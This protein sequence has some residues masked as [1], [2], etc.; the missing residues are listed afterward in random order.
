[1]RLYHYASKNN[2]ILSDGL[3]SYTT[4]PTDLKRYSSYAKSSKRKDVIDWMEKTFPGRSKS[5]SCLTEP[6]KWRGNDPVL[7]KIVKGSTLF[8]F[9]LDDLIKDGLVQSI[10]C[11]D[12]LAKKGKK[13][14]IHK[15]C[16]QYF[17]QVKPNEIDTSPLTWDKVDA[18][19][20]LLYGAVRHYMS[21]LKK[22]TIPPKYI[23]QEKN[24]LISI[25]SSLIKKYLYA[26]NTGYIKRA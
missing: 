17:Y 6:M 15:G 12:D 20:E 2:T 24:D 19:N 16:V 10:W 4:H 14:R 3:F 1:M 5:I 25:L 9:E 7:K 23:R 21:V 26:I 11:R 18:K 8:S 22:G 13:L